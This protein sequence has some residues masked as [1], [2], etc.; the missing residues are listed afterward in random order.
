MLLVGLHQ[1]WFKGID[2]LTTPDGCVDSHIAV[3]VVT[4]RQY[5]DETEEVD[6][7]IY[8][9][10]GKTNQKLEGGNLA[11]EASQRIGN[12]VRV[13]RGEEDPNN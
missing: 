13:I 3:S 2:Y 1:R 8:M 4:S 6:S 11:L 10:Q 7:L 9:G 12:E 5:N